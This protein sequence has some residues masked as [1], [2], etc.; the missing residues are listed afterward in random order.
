MSAAFY[1]YI[2]EQLTTA[3]FE[4]ATD[5]VDAIKAIKSDEEIQ[6]IREVCAMQDELFEYA[7]TRIHPGRRD[8][9]IYADILHKCLEIGGEQTNIL[10]GSVP[11]NTAGKHLPLHFLNRMVEDGDQFTLLL[12]ANGPSG[13]WAELGRTICLG[14]AS[15]ELKEQC[16]LAI[17]AQQLTLSLLKPGADPTAIF[18]ANNE[19]LISSGYPEERRIFAH[20]MG[21]D[22]VER[23][24]ID[25]GETMKIEAR[26]NIA[27]HPTVASAKASGWVCENYIISE[28]GEHECLHKTPQKVFVI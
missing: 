6:L 5:M 26:M 15:P 12:E 21:Y 25:C 7:L 10:G 27:V 28:T 1:K 22:M 2:V 9:E 23:P 17:K 8:Y 19:F 11:A 20:G 4:D 14:K 24:A 13:L 16:E 3:K 18:K